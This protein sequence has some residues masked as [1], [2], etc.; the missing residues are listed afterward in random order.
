MVDSLMLSQ[1]HC[2]QVWFHEESQNSQVSRYVREFLKC[3]SSST[4]WLPC[5]LFNY[6]VY[7]IYLIKFEGACLQ[8]VHS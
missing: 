2:P 1:K 7:V 8:N 6:L 4:T 5:Y 3:E